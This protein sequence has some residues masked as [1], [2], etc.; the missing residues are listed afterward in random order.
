MILLSRLANVELSLREEEVGNVTAHSYA[1]QQVHFWRQAVL[2]PSR[3]FGTGEGLV[4]CCWLSLLSRLAVKK[5][6]HKGAVKYMDYC[7][8]I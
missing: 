7:P 6:L 5:T 2:V 1:L 8:S 4:R 3:T